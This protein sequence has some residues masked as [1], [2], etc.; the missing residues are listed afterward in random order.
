MLLMKSPTFAINYLQIEEA[1]LPGFCQTVRT[2]TFL[3]DH[4]LKLN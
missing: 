4:A 1:C 3:N 2:I